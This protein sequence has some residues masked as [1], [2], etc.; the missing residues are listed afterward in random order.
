MGSTREISKY[1]RRYIYVMTNRTKVTGEP[2][3]V[4]DSEQYAMILYLQQKRVL[5]ERREREAKEKAKR[6]KRSREG[7]S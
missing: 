4:I 2:K 6:A 5:R 1:E 3:D 7:R